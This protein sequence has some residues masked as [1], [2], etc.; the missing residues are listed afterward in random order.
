MRKNCYYCVQ[1]Y[2]LKLH[3]SV[4]TVRIEALVISRNKFLCLCLKSLPRVSL[5]S[6]LERD[7]GCKEV[8][9]LPV[10][11]Q[12]LRLSSCMQTHI[13]M[14][15]HYT[16]CHCSMSFVLDIHTQF[17]SLSQY[18]F[19]TILVPWCIN[20]TINSPSLSRKTAAISFLVGRQ[21]L[22]L[23]GLFHECVC[24][25]RSDCSLLY[26]FKNVKAEVILCVL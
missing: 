3:L 1:K 21:C 26:H 16:R 20:V 18:T 17:F 5:A 14:E 12:C 9:Q 22:N 15:E 19:D 4:V 11:M 13:V 25:H 24:I 6:H 23:L 8:G 2:I 7:Q 10:V